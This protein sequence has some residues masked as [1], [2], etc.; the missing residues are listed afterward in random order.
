MTDGADD[1]PPI[2]EPEPTPRKKQSELRPLSEIRAELRADT[3][4][5]SRGQFR[6]GRQ[7]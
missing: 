6:K 7:V 3:A 4:A 5:R 2:E 1:T